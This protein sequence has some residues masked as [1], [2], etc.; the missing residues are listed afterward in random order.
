MSPRQ[1]HTVAGGGDAPDAALVVCPVAQPLRSTYG[2][3]MPIKPG[4][5]I[6][7]LTT[8]I[9]LGLGSPARAATVGI[10][11]DGGLTY[12]AAPGETNDVTIQQPRLSEDG[13][14]YFMGVRELLAPLTLGEGCTPYVDPPV[15]CWPVYFSAPVHVYLGD[16]NDRADSDPFY[17]DSYVWGGAGD[18]DIH[19][20]G[21]GEGKA[22]GGPG[23]DTI[24]VGA[25][26]VA[27][28]Y[29]GPGN[30]QL[31]AGA[32]STSLYGESGDDVLV[33]YPG[34]VG[35]FDGGVGNDTITTGQNR[36]A[37]SPEVVGGPGDDLINAAG[38]SVNAGVG[39]DTITGGAGTADCTF[40][41]PVDKIDAGPGDDRIDV[42]GDSA[43]ERPDQV[44][45]GAGNDVVYADPSDVIAADCE[46]R[47]DGPVAATTM[48]RS[49][50]RA[51]QQARRL[52]RS[53]PA[54]RA[55]GKA[56]AG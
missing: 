33:G 24:R 51:K 54:I 37:T 49:V 22:W 46:T 29:G 21:S 7:L 2:R 50:Q 3:H 56:L 14:T 27:S 28:G 34:F 55:R 1:A 11:S 6:V 39:N 47:R 23:N 45:C 5:R 53:G 26:F 8:L 41:C 38:G 13:R 35:L 17:A 18:D 9:A 42:S 32:I 48:L 16:G 52:L 31:L 36:H 43:A 10:Q 30:D 15:R 19:S 40:S 4:C 20:D 44:S 25:E 12:E